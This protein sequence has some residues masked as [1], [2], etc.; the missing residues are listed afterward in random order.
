MSSVLSV[1][2]GLSPH[3]LQMM[4]GCV[5]ELGL[6]LHAAGSER[7][8]QILLPLAFSG[9][10]LKDTVPLLVQLALQNGEHW[11][12]TDRDW[13]LRS[14]LAATGRFC[15]PGQLIVHL[16]ILTSGN[17]FVPNLGSYWPA[18]YISPHLLT[19][20]SVNFKFHGFSAQASKT[21]AALSQAQRRPSPATNPEQFLCH[22]S[23]GHQ[24]LLLEALFY[25]LTFLPYLCPSSYMMPQKRVEFSPPC[26]LSDRDFS[27]S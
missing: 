4:S 20:E 9:S 23:H 17:I 3:P 1:S 7:Q 25:Y 12:V 13:H 8:K 27:Q 19:R 24:G 6:R 2:F 14:F 10:S 16:K 18:V 15:G 5:G 21:S 11:E 26:L 22:T